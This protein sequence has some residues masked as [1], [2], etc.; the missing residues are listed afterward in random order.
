MGDID[1]NGETEGEPEGIGVTCGPAV[2]GAFVAAA[3]S[4]KTPARAAATMVRC[5]RRSMM[6][7]A[8]PPASGG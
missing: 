1:G 6:L 4:A 8:Y 3:P 7:M 5:N 2:A